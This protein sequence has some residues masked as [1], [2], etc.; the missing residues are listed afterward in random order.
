M[1]ATFIGGSQAV[2]VQFDEA[3]TSGSGL[4]RYQN[5]MTGAC[6]D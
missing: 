5:S 4:D 3:A 2:G 1:P 6:A